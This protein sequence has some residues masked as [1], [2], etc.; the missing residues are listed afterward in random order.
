M[1]QVNVR[2]AKE[3][4]ICIAR[5]LM[6]RIAIAINVIPIMANVHIVTA[7]VKEIEKITCRGLNP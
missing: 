1:A 4:D 5:L 3:T 7:Q 2:H 6:K